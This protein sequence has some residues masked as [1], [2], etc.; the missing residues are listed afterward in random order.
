MDIPV[1]AILAWLDRR[2]V[3]LAI[4]FGIALRLAGYFVAR[5][6]WMDESSLVDNIHSLTPIGFFRP[7]RN[8]QLAPPAFLVAVWSMVQ[9]FGENVYA[10]RLVPLAGGI[11]SMFL[12]AAVA[13]R[14][15]PASAVFPAVMMFAVANDPIYYASE[16][17]Q[18]STDVA[19]CLAWLTAAV[20][21][22]PKELT[23]ARTARFAL[24]GAAIVWFSHPS[25]F[26]LASVGLVGLAGAIASRDGKRAMAWGIV[27]VAWVASFAGVHRVAQTQLG[28]EAHQMWV[29]WG[30][31]FPPIP[32]ESFW[33][34]TWVFRRLAFFFINP[35]NFDAPFGERISLLPALGLAIVG[36]FRLWKLDR[37]RFALLALPFV[38]TLTAATFRLYPFHGRLLLFLCPIPL[39]AVAAGLDAIGQARWRGVLYYA[40][41]TMVVVVPTALAVQQVFEPRYAHNSFGDLHPNTTNP[42]IFPY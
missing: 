40:L 12:F 21:I 28:R 11:G 25:I 4:G 32:P 20:A 16:I 17:K 13:R 5:G 24:G 1:F 29:F 38:L 7:L 27:G 8:N 37:S 41:A 31:A 42:F 33:D 35:L 15:L 23:A 3:A 2:K 10:T 30:F 34:A 19:A 9:V 14:F 36:A 18:Y 22:G 39:I 6:Y 26:V